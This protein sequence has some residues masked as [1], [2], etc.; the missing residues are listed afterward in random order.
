MRLSLLIVC[1]LMLVDPVTARQASVRGFVTDALTEQPLQGASVVLLAPHNQQPMGVA[2]DGD[3]F[4]HVRRVPAGTYTLRISFIGFDAYEERITLAA[5]GTLDRSVVLSPSSGEIDELVVE[6]DAMGGVATVAAGLETI[7]PASIDR[8]P[9]P[10]V[11]G[12]L[13]AYLQTVPGV[14]VSG[15]RGGQ[16]FVRGGA[17]DQNLALLDGLPVYMPFHVLSFYSAFPEELVDRAA[18]HTGGFGAAYGGR[19][20]S[21]LDV[22]ARNGNKQHL[23]GGISLAPFLSTVRLEGP[24]VPGRVSAVVSARQSL[25]E[26]FVPEMFGQSMPYRFGDRFGKIHALLGTSHTL[27]FTALDTDDRGDIAGTRKVFTGDA[28][29]GEVT[30]STQIHWSNRVYG[31]QWIFRPNGAPIVAQVTAGRSEMTNSFGPEEARSRTGSIASTDLALKL[32]WL[33]RSGRLTVGSSLR[34]ADLTYVLDDQFQDL[35]TGS[36]VLRELGSF[37][38]WEYRLAG[39][40]IVA[41]SGLHLYSGSGDQPGATWESFLEPRFRLT[42]HPTG[43]EGRHTVHASAGTYH[44]KLT[45]LSDKRDLG[46]LFTAWVVAENAASAV[47]V[48]LGYN[49]RLTPFASAAVEAWYK[50]YTGLSVPIFS[51]F[52]RFTTI[53]QS[54]DGRAYGTDVRLDFNGRPFISDAT[55][56]GYLSYSFSSVEYETAT[57]TYNP[58]HDRPHQLNALLHAEKG[59][60]GLTLQWQYGSG[61]PFTPSGGFD[62]W[63]VLTPG[64]DLTR[65]QGE[66][67]VLYAEPYSDR[68][69][70]YSR[71]DLWIERRVERGRHVATVRAGALNI[72]NRANLFYFDLFT[73]QRVDQ[74][75]LIPSVGLKVELR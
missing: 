16:F 62:K 61:L 59:E 9:V 29:A 6:A 57:H 51:A 56:D 21:I 69:P 41:T 42:Y 27:S 17:V 12:D 45:G 64:V 19:T 71:V 1:L 37:V 38:E 58:G 7:V 14:V 11:S 23:A 2:T 22:Q 20:S 63:Y 8:V 5:T 40:R 3:G 33:L 36:D 35:T 67:R 70:S 39:D 31:G 25:I 15:D 4:F 50:D 65:Q 10:G 55:L 66:D 44:Q 54:A 30:D 60:V 73:F 26:E 43:P 28:L 75:P 52:P 46:N 34:Q 24:I 48:I 18:F 72:L 49:V 53:L 47:H 68:L 13:A 32:D 74:L